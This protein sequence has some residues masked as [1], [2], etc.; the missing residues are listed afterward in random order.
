MRRE[1]P[2]FHV[3][4]LRMQLPEIL[5]PYLVLIVPH[6]HPSDLSYYYV[7][8]LFI[9]RTLQIQSVEQSTASALRT[10]PLVSPPLAHDSPQVQR[11]PLAQVGRVHVHEWFNFIKFRLL[12]TVLHYLYGVRQA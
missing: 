11:P 2:R 4:V 3:R 1:M 7:V 9:V 12:L 10:P 5:L 8:L 6:C